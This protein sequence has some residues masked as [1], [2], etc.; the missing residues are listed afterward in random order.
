MFG[1]N[2]AGTV[3]TYTTSVYS[4]NRKIHG[5]GDIAEINEIKVF[6]A[7]YEG[8]QVLHNHSNS[9]RRH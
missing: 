9:I 8:E 4:R 7:I 2:V 3:N 1:M 6:M 5:S